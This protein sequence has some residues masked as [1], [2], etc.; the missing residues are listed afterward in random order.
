MIII[1]FVKY[2][3][4]FTSWMLSYELSQRDLLYFEMEIY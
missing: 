1:E 4:H 3:L 2:G